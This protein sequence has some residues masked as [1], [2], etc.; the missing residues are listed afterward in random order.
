MSVWTANTL[1][2]SY[3][4]IYSGLHSQVQGTIFHPRLEIWKLW[5]WY[6]LI[7]AGVSAEVTETI[8]NPNIDPKKP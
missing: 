3:M 4:F 7:D 5:V 2:V 8:L 6:Q 1:V